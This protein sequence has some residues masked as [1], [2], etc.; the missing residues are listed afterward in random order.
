ME[1]SRRV[2]VHEDNKEDIPCVTGVVWRITSV[3]SGAVHTTCVHV[4]V[5]AVNLFPQVQ[6]LALFKALA[7]FI[8][9]AI[10]QAEQGPEN[11]AV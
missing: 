2:T 3:A 6:R 9:L 11:E 10:W 4:N 7:S 5:C 8:L 1:M